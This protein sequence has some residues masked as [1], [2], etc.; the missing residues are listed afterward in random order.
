MRRSI[1]LETE[2][3]GN[4]V[5][6]NE[7]EKKNNNKRDRISTYW[8]RIWRLRMVSQFDPKLRHPA[9]IKCRVPIEQQLH[10]KESE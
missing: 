3:G 7:K 4:K 2:G 1:L 8:M 9:R 10:T 6:M 5:A